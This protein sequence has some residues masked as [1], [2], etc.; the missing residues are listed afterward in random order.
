MPVPKPLSI[1]TVVKICA[2]NDDEIYVTDIVVD[3]QMWKVWIR[4]RWDCFVNYEFQEVT[5]ELS[6]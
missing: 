4:L 6:F 3:V 5:V 2:Y 1:H